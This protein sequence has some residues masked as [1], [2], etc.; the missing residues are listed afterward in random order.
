MALPILYLVNMNKNVWIIQTTNIFV[1]L[2]LV[3]RGLAAFSNNIFAIITQMAK[4]E[5]GFVLIFC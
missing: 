4:A 3:F 5:R 1:R 2:T